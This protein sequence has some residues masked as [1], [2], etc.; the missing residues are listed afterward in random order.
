MLKYLN[1]IY[2]SIRWR[3]SIELNNPPQVKKDNYFYA[4]ILVDINKSIPQSNRKNKVLIVSACFSTILEDDKSFI[5][6]YKPA[7]DSVKRISQYPIN[8]HHTKLLN[9]QFNDW[10]HKNKYNIHRK[11]LNVYEDENK[12]YAVIS[13]E[14]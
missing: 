3:H 10:T 4:D 14:L 13:F 7:N 5:E 6:N 8:K 9:N 2:D 1:A 11:K 12:I